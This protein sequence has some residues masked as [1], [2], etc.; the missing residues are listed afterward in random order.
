MLYFQA[1][2]SVG[3]SSILLDFIK[4]FIDPSL[5]KL[6]SYK[7][8]MRIESRRSNLVHDGIVNLNFKLEFLVLSLFWFMN[9]AMSLGIK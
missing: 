8:N 2:G 3:K 9:S 4:C 7:I 6:H 1:T 5:N